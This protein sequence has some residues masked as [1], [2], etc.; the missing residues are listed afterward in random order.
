MKL[1]ILSLLTIF[2]LYACS[3]DATQQEEAIKSVTDESSYLLFTRV[4][5]EDILPEE[6][7]NDL[8]I[9]VFNTFTQELVRIKQLGIDQ[10][11]GL[12]YKLP[13]GTYDFYFLANV[14]NQAI[15]WSSIKTI[16]DLQTIELNAI[17]EHDKILH[18]GIPMIDH[19]DEVEV[20]GG[21]T[22][23]LPI[24]FDEL[25]NGRDIKLMR[26]MSKFD[27]HLSGS[28]FSL[29]AKTD[30]SQV[31]SVQLMNV[32]D[33]IHPFNLSGSTEDALINV[34]LDLSQKDVRA[35]F[36]EVTVYVPTRYVLESAKWS[37]NSDDI[38]YLKIVLK[39]GEEFQI[40]LVSNH[41]KHWSHTKYMAFAEGLQ[42]GPNKEKP[43]Y[44]ILP[45]TNYQ[46]RLNLE[47]NNLVIEVLVKPWVYVE[48]S[49]DDFIKPIYEG[50]RIYLNQD[51]LAFGDRFQIRK[52][53]ATPYFYIW[54]QKPK[55]S[56]WR[57]NSTNG[58]NFQ[59]VG[60]SS[61]SASENPSVGESFAYLK[62]RVIPAGNVNPITEVYFTINNEEIPLT[63]IFNDGSEV[64]FFSKNRFKVELI[65]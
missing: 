56:T 39:T 10:S 21:G 16:G 32:S 11:T 38:P 19:I 26:T 52:N 43:S 3:T 50:A 17:W 29:P 55:G 53:E 15:D 37:A 35:M 65:Q 30:L 54:L 22:Q 48:V 2:G 6:Y 1:F 7:V 23:E 47:N 20:L 42:L 44:S 4:S 57:L 49:N 58:L 63:V 8:T 62:S 28:G 45:N 5:N 61:G 33:K 14:A 64:E 41:K 51:D 59:I 27:L 40:P 46:Y 9:L 18:H 25:V 12:V 34:S 36:H 60:V 24:R 13:P 31:A